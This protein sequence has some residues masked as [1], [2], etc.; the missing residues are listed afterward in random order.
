MH[1]T[2][3]INKDVH[4]QNTANK[5]YEQIGHIDAWRFCPSKVH[6][7]SPNCSQT[8]ICVHGSP[9]KKNNTEEIRLKEC[10]T[11]TYTPV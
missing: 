4:V 6:V 1:G 3:T 8:V 5:A 10:N 9:T 11:Y 2:F 7:A